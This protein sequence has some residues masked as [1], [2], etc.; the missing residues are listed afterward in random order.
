MAEPTT[1]TTEETDV[2]SEDFVITT[3]KE[4][5][6]HY[7]ITLNESVDLAF[8]YEKIF[9]TLR[10]LPHNVGSVNL[11]L[12]NYGG[13]IQGLVPLYNAIHDCVV[14][15]NV[16]VTSNSYSCGALLA[17][18]GATLTMRPNT[19]LM[20]HNYSG[21]E[22]GKGKELID[23]AQASQKNIYEAFHYMAYPF[24]SK[25]EIKD[26]YHDHD[27]YINWKGKSYGVDIKD[28]IERHF[29]GRK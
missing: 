20:F 1:P 18:A 8:K 21:G 4:E 22:Y 14:P 2:S 28:R 16:I 19:Q 6:I 9:A 27:K 23:A 3:R 10:D 25:E 15:V 5:V 24:L 17:L 11:Y 26:L 29:K 7:D 13:Y 12:A